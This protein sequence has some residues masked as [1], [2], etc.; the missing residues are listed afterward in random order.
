L[1]SLAKCGRFHYQSSNAVL[2]LGKS[3]FVS[4]VYGRVTSLQ[5]VQVDR[6][7]RIVD[8]R[9]THCYILPKAKPLRKPLSGW[10]RRFKN[11]TG[12]QLFFRCWKCYG[13]TCSNCASGSSAYS[14][15]TFNYRM[16]RSHS[17]KVAVLKFARSLI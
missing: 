12:P 1:H 13:C 17:G 4:T 5:N 2:L 10:Y 6:D 15:R 8:A 11:A 9:I 16:G 14:L 3:E 7:V